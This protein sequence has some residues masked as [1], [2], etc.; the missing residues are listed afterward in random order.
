[1]Y[2]LVATAKSKFPY[3]RTVLSGGL[4]RREVTWRRDRYVCVWKTLGVTIVDPNS[5]IKDGDFG[6]DGVHLNRR[7]AWRLWHLCSRVCNFSGE[8]PAGGNKWQWRYVLAL[9]RQQKVRDS[10]LS[11]NIRRSV[12]DRRRGK[13]R[14]RIWRG[15]RL[16]TGFGRNLQPRQRHAE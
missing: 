4:Q 6:R 13:W 12:G 5:W 14:R 7:R 16:K 1:M 2:P 11:R 8:G 3:C 9:R 10:R 15:A